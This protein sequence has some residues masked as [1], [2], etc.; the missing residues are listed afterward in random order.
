MCCMHTL[1]PEAI[2]IKGRHVDVHGVAFSVGRA[3][4]CAG[5]TVRW[6]TPCTWCKTVFSGWSTSCILRVASLRATASKYE[7]LQS[8]VLYNAHRKYDLRALTKERPSAWRHPFLKECPSSKERLP[9]TF[10][11]ISCIGAKFN[12]MSA[13]LQERARAS[14]WLIQQTRRVEKQSHTYQW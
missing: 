5:V 8:L 7:R 12:Q 11:L 10:G 1:N 4:R 2:C 9:S 3:I 6:E 14:A 13:L